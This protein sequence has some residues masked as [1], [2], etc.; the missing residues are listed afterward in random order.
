MD[1]DEVVELHPSATTGADCWSMAVGCAALFQASQFD[2][3]P[4]VE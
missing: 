3:F 1:N 4:P 2:R